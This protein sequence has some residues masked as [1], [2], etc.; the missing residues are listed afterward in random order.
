MLRSLQIELVALAVENGLHG[1]LHFALLLALPGLVQ[2]AFCKVVPSFKLAPRFFV[3]HNILPRWVLATL[4][5][6]LELLSLS[7][8]LL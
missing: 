7:M 4:G 5:P 6:D 8:V 1:L 2:L 3:V